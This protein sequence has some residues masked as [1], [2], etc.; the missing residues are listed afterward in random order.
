[1]LNVTVFPIIII[2]SPR[3]GS[4]PLAYE[5]KNR[6]NIE[7]FNE[8]LNKTVGGQYKTEEQSKFLSF[9]QD[10]NYILKL[11]IN[12][13]HNYPS[14]IL[15]IIENHQCT[16]I[17]IRRRDIVS[18]IASLYIETKRDV[19]GYF[20]EFNSSEKIAQFTN[21]DIPIT[22]DLVK[23]IKKVSSINEQLNNS[24][25]DFD[26]DVWYEDLTFIDQSFIT[27]PKP[28]NY[29]L[30]QEKIRNLLANKFLIRNLLDR[31]TLE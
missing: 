23:C 28:K 11:H 22:I 14:N 4:T 15:N 31:R 27:T 2:S 19:W 10:N 13:L 6:Y 30:I 8:P 5:L 3:T 18:Q 24:K 25:Y 17:R 16:L 21:T 29:N 7:L 9:I 1:M 20:K 26:S 12:D